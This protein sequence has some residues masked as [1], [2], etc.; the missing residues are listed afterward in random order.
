M[1]YG[2]K[3]ISLRRMKSNRYRRGSKSVLNVKTKANFSLGGRP[4]MAAVLVMVPLLAAAVV[5]LG[6][7]LVQRM[8]ME[9][10]MFT[11]RQVNIAGGKVLSE[12]MIR[13]YT[14]ISEGSNIFEFEIN[15]IRRDILSR[16]KNVRDIQICRKLPCEVD[17]VVTERVPLARLGHDGNLVVDIDGCVF[18]ARAGLT[19]LPVLKGY[20]GGRMV[21][22][23]RLDGM[24]LP[25]LT[26]LETLRFELKDE[27]DV[28]MVAVDDP[29]KI[30][31]FLHD[32]RSADLS[33]NAMMEGGD[34]SKRS[35]ISKLGKMMRA[36]QDPRP[37]HFDSTFED[38]IIGS[39]AS[40]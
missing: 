13:E 22:G 35:L 14:R 38:R 34:E 1:W 8:F 20:R 36:L 39:S 12:D 6:W 40:L 10:E 26:L 18:A 7:F 24:S 31:I 3:E 33:W 25:A 16:A 21:P 30:T 37:A 2:D 17:I 5:F 9:N 15:R 28:R 27:I 32:G 19:E 29:E 23:N 4:Y 11:V